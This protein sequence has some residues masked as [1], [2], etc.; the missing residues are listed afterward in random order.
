VTKPWFRI[1]TTLSLE[2]HCS[3]I[4][5]KFRRKTPNRKKQLRSFDRILFFAVLFSLLWISHTIL[6]QIYL[7]K[8]EALRCKKQIEKAQRKGRKVQKGQVKKEKNRKHRVILKIKNMLGPA[9]KSFPS[10]TVTKQ[11]SARLEAKMELKRR[12]E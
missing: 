1:E 2:K 6:Q 3:K 5:S 8:L 12:L 10:F 7:F 11:K 4:K 9:N